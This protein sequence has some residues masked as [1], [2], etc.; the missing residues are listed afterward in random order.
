MS[1]ASS[2]ATNSDASSR[3]GHHYQQQYRKNSRLGTHNQPM[4]LSCDVGS[5]NTG[6]VRRR[7]RREVGGK[8]NRMD[9][10]RDDRLRQQQHER[11]E[12]QKDEDDEE[13]EAATIEGIMISENMNNII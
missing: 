6:N 10:A 3:A 2:P 1:A 9:E 4:C 7:E 5:S 11:W 12:H 13:K 8:Q